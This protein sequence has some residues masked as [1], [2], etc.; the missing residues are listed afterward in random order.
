VLENFYN[1]GHVNGHDEETIEEIIETI[2]RRILVNITVGMDKGLGTSQ[3]EVYHLQVAVPLKAQQKAEDR[4]FYAYNV[5]SN[6]EN[7]D[8]TTKTWHETTANENNNDNQ[9]TEDDVTVSDATATESTITDMDFD[10]ST[11]P[12]SLCDCSD[13]NNSRFFDNRGLDWENFLFVMCY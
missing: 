11:I 7:V 9:N 3:Q 13:R 8:K 10:Y 4:E 1:T 2:E 5:H 6:D 12:V